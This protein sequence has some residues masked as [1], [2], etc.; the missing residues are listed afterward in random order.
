[1]PVGLNPFLPVHGAVGYQPVIQTLSEG[2]PN[3]APMAVVSADRRYVRVSW[4]SGGPMFSSIPKVTTFNYST[5]S[6]SSSSNPG[7]GGQGFTGG[8]TGSGI[9]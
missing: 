3:Y 1:M 9:Q 2:M 7:T 5:G 6:S 8:D 4:P